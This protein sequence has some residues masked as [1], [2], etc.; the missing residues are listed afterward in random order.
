MMTLKFLSSLAGAMLLVLTGSPQET[1]STGGS[2]QGGDEPQSKKESP[3][4]AKKP[5][6]LAGHPSTE[7]IWPLVARSHV[8]A[9]GTLGVPVEA[10]RACLSSKQHKYVELTVSRDKVLKG[11]PPATFPVRWFTRPEKNGP[12]PEYVIKL[13]GKRVLL[14]LLE[15]DETSAKGLYFAGDMTRALVET[16]TGLLEQVRGEVAAQQKL[17]KRFDD[18][19]PPARE[20]LHARVKDLIDAATRK[21]TQMVAFRQLEELGEKAVPAI[22][23]L[24]DDRR[25]LAIP[26]ITLSNPPRHWEAVRHYGP[27]K[28]VDALA[29]I[30]N[31]LTG[32]SFGFI[33]NGGTERERQAAIEG[34]RI[35]LH[36]WKQASE[37][38]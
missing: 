23:M 22:I 27:K 28:V 11:N 1:P 12:D 3:A 38:K 35:F 31:Q 10:I 26:Q 15:V 21:D 24:M 30:L 14:F 37:E 18:A 13:N 33:Y 29:A 20:P 5:A 8:I 34:W 19:W 36:R 7:E 17:L 9:T 6:S 2:R 25:D 32:E 4:G 16:N